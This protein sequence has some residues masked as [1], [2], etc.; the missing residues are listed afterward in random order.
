VV[1]NEIKGDLD[2]RNWISGILGM[3]F[4]SLLVAG[5][6]MQGGPRGSGSYLAGQ[7]AALGLGVLI[8]V[9][10]IFYLR[11]ALRNRESLGSGL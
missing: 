6:L 2:M 10:G 3:A 5:Q 9:F 7:Y 11:K 1:F 4:G 8:L